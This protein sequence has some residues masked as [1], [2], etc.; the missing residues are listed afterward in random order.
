[1]TTN[2]YPQQIPPPPYY[3]YY[4]PRESNGLGIA[5]FVCGLVGLAL[6]WIFL[7]GAVLPLI[8]LC[9]SISAGLR[10]RNGSTNGFSVAGI[11][12]SLVGVT[13]QLIIVI[14]TIGLLASV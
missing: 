7:F 11:V 3:P 5:G 9:L 13:I 12:L 1:M 4:P 14:V 10:F 6:S 2:S 8:G